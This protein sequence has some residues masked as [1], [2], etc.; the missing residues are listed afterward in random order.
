LYENRHAVHCVEGGIPSLCL[1]WCWTSVTRIVMK[2]SYLLSLVALILVVEGKMSKL[3]KKLISS[4]RL[5]ALRC[6]NCN[7]EFSTQHAYDCHG[8][9]RRNAETPCADPSS[10]RSVTFTERQ[11]LSTGILREHVPSFLG[12]ISHNV[13]DLSANS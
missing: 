11:D 6:K 2:P 13:C 12:N 8:R 5:V 10:Q 9:H 3:S 4:M 1:T 7:G